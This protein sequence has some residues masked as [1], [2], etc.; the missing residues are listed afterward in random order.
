MKYFVCYTPSCNKDQCQILQT[1]SSIEDARNYI[2]N[3][4]GLDLEKDEL[5]NYRHYTEDDE[6]DESKYNISDPSLFETDYD[7]ERYIFDLSSDFYDENFN[8]TCSD[9]GIY[10]HTVW[11]FKCEDNTTRSNI[12]KE[13]YIM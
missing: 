1:E 9:C 10:D 11:I 6:K 3:L 5:K 4:V 2:I 13:L 7:Y 12:L 8:T